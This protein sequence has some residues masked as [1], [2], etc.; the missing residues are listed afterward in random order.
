[1]TQTLAERIRV[2]DCDAH[3]VEPYDLWTSR[4]GKRWGERVP[5]VRKDPKRGDDRWY[6]GE[7]RSWAA[8]GFAM[9]G[10]HEWPPDHP[11]TLADADPACWD[12][13]ARLERMDGYGIFAEVLFP[14]AS[15]FNKAQ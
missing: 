6:F 11:P 4:L 9:A 13:A 12:A 7:V 8:G 5:H 10:W 3:I 14:S 1:M 2:V 15:G